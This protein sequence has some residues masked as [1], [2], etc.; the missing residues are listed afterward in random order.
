MKRFL[1][2]VS[3]LA[4]VGAC[5]APNP[6]TVVVPDQFLITPTADESAIWP[7]QQWWTG[8]ENAELTTLI[9]TANTNSRNLKAAAARILQAEAAAKAAGATLFPSVSGN[10]G[11]GRSGGDSRADSTSTQV[12]LSASYQ[13]DLFG[14]VH[15][16]VAAANQRID[17]SLFDR[18][19]VRIT[20]FSDVATTYLQ[21]LA[22][23]DRLR[24]AEERLRIAEDLLAL[25][26]AQRRIGVIS[27]LEL[28]QQRSAI[29]SQRAAIPG[30]LVSERQTLDALAVLLSVLPEKFSVE[31]RTLADLQLPTIASGIPAELL[32][33]RPDLRS[34][35]SNLR[36]NG[37]D[38]A[39]ARAARLPS[40]Q[41]TASGG[42]ASA[43]LSGLFNS[44]TFFTNI[45]ASLAAPLFQGG[46]LQAQ[47]QAVRARRMELVETY[48]QS[49][50]S[51]FRDVEDAL[52]A[53]T[54]NAV[55]YGFAEEAYRQ[56]VE[57]YRLAELR[58][59]NGVVNFQ[60]VLNAQTS[61]LQTQEALVSSGLA[62]LTAVV[63]L[64]KALGGGWDGATPQRLSL[65]EN[66]APL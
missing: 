32:D 63:T 65:A 26:E 42:T 28:T 59:R 53:A 8:F 5:A 47:E 17:T 2:S 22:I 14:Q 29:A 20:L 44:G 3:I 46:R 38:V 24:L 7:S 9:E 18:E 19:T 51:A 1:F 49:V 33:R 12:G 35:E 34:A 11:I 37:F 23:R 40:L 66:L 30:L 15:N 41:L 4:L 6:P 54:Q 62:R 64:T 60:T 36:A 55:Q 56:A 58:Y 16:N 10:A 48:Q 50:I 13:V 61:V 45:G 31:G 21:L 39:A 25:V 57:A 43:A 27:D 52:A